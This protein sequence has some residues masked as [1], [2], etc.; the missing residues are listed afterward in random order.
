MKIYLWLFLFAWISVLA[1]QQKPLILSGRVLDQ[2]S[3]RPLPG[4]DVYLKTAGSG[5]ASGPDGHFMLKVNAEQMAADTLVVRYLGYRSAY[6]AL[7][8]FRSP[9]TILLQ[10]VELK[11]EQIITVIG[12]RINLKNQE[13]PHL[14]EA[15]SAREIKELNKNE[16]VQI[17]KLLP[18]VTVQGNLL[19]G[20]HIEIRGSQTNEVNV[21]LDGI[22]LNAFALDHSADLSIVPV[23]QI[24]RLEIVKGGNLPLYGQGAFG[25]AVN[26]IT[27][28]SS[29]P[30]LNVKIAAGDFHSRFVSAYANVPFYSRFQLSYFGQKNRMEPEIEFFPGERFTAKT[31][32]YQIKID[33]ETHHLGI[34]YFSAFGQGKGSVFKYGLNY[35]KPNWQ[36]DRENLIFAFQFH[37]PGNFSLFANQGFIT[38]ETVRL[39]S[40]QSKY[41][42]K[43]ETEQLH[44]RLLKKFDFQ[45]IGWQF[46]AEYFHERTKT[47]AFIIDSLGKVPYSRSQLY[48][49]RAAVS[50]VFQFED[51]YQPNAENL[52]W[53]VYLG[54]RADISASGYR[55]FSPSVGARLHWKKNGW[56]LV[57]Y[58][59]YGKNVKYPGL[60]E[61]ARL[62]NLV[63]IFPAD[64]V[65]QTL[66]PEYNTSSELGARWNYDYPGVWLGALEAQAAVFLS[67]TMNKI[68][69]QPY[70]EDFFQSQTGRNTTTGLE[71]SLKLKRIYHLFQLNFSALLLNIDNPLLYSYK[72]SR[73]FTMGLDFHRWRHFYWNTRLFYEGESK[74]WYF[75]AARQLRSVT[76]ASHYDMDVT[77]G[78][79]AS[80]GPVHLDFQISGNNIFDQSAYKY[81]YI[82]KRYWQAGLTLRY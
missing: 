24:E 50:S 1:G 13:I 60:L 56:E 37:L 47:S 19:D 8:E 11:M 46:G 3:D 40:L 12:E 67:T 44:L 79:A 81:Y 22:L 63:V 74:A 21:Y 35:Q 68:L 41:S 80:L 70:G 18:S 30:E 2:T 34:N 39:T 20:H 72:P 82:Y 31:S 32:N 53:R 51:H 17:L 29:R 73:R 61:Q 78:L 16:M 65:R 6:F 64:T 27:R 23:D 71:A 48:D 26:I 43:N 66:R 14:V 5:T 59:N 54:A 9:H 77:V 57:P 52:F 36:D 38:D 75:D 28:Q 4:A 10:P 49:N 33:H 76:V 45:R 42:N 15:V 69:R 25:G 55:D 58:F 62:N 7:K